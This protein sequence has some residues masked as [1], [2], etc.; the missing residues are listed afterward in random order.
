MKTFEHSHN[1]S[2]EGDSVI[3]SQ[4]NF[5]A[6]NAVLPG[7][8]RALEPEK[9]IYVS[10]NHREEDDDFL[11]KNI[12]IESIRYFHDVDGY[13]SDH[14]FT[15]Q[16]HHLD[17]MFVHELSKIIGD[18]HFIIGPAFS[19]VPSFLQ[20]RL[21]DELIEYDVSGVMFDMREADM[22]D[23][24]E[25]QPLAKLKIHAKNR[26]QIIPV[27]GSKQQKD[28]LLNNIPFDIVYIHPRQ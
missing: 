13:V 15:D 10:I 6:P 20:S 3:L 18:K 11:R 2:S 22:D 4:R 24:G 9:E 17:A 26:I 14:V 16:F 5:N 19:N 23:F 8:L 7:M 25:L 12:I 27:V 1:L 21:M 28:E